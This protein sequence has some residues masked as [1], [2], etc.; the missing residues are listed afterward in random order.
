MTK[1]NNVMNRLTTNLMI[2][3]C[4]L[5]IL[6]TPV[7]TVN[8]ASFED[9]FRY[10]GETLQTWEKIETISKAV[11]AAD[12]SDDYKTIT[13]IYHQDD[14]AVEATVKVTN[15]HISVAEELV[16]SFVNETLWNSFRDTV[17]TDSGNSLVKVDYNS[18][19]VSANKQ[20]GCSSA[21]YSQ[22]KS[23]YSEVSGGTAA[24]D[25]VFD[26][27][28]NNIK[29]EA[30]EITDAILSKVFV[31]SNTIIYIGISLVSIYFALT[32][33]ADLA[34]LIAPTFRRYLISVDSAD[35]LSPD[36]AA[37]RAKTKMLVGG[38]VSETALLSLGCKR[39]KETKQL[40]L[41]DARSIGAEFMV[42]D[43]KYFIIHKCS[44]WVVITIFLII[45][46]SG[47]LGQL[48]SLVLEFM[49]WVYNS[50]LN[51]LRG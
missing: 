33:V 34:F 13:C 51:L 45:F 46:W 26:V 38:F 5:S 37:K 28:G 17:G 23:Q 41:T 47:Q 39:D 32:V 49:T 50:V 35:D 31:L 4:A 11:S 27:L 19:K 20:A 7:Q 36:A 16:E 18:K 9:A 22:L 30:N 21:M 43:W 14:Q 2:L 8:A 44:M 10:F 24:N 3:V 40:G 6:V 12:L 42:P 29:P 15:A 1:F 25:F 48:A